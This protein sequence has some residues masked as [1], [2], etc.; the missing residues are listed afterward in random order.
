MGS[1]AGHK[2]CSGTSNV[3]LGSQAALCATT[4]QN[5]VVIGLV[6]GKSLSTGTNNVLV[7]RMAGCQM[8]AGSSNVMMGN[9]AGYC[10]QGHHNLMFGQ[11]SG[12]HRAGSKYHRNVLLGSYAGRT[13]G[14]LAVGNYDIL[15]GYLAGECYTGTCSIG[16]GHSLRMPIT[17]GTNQLAIGQE[18]NYWITGSCDYNVGIGISIPTSKLHVVGD[19]C[20]SGVSTVSGGVCLPNNSVL[21][22]GQGS[23]KTTFHADGTD[24]HLSLIHI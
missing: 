10:A 19:T 14:T 5:S 1:S 16:I 6:A 23:Y 13:A 9:C 17:A 15:I 4:T 22:L 20:V 11:S 8:H 24:T 18:T 21:T 2:L 3:F 12:H 7:G